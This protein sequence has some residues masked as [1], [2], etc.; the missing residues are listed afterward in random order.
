[1]TQGPTIDDT[2]VRFEKV[3]RQLEEKLQEAEK[4]QAE[5]RTGLQ[6]IIDAQALSREL[7][8]IG[9]TLTLMIDEARKAL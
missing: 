7:N 4:E 6:A 3:E 2:F 1:M 8:S 9:M 5:G